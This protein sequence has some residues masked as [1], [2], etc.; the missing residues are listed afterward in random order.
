MMFSTD[1]TGQDA[2]NGHRRACSPLPE[3]KDMQ[4]V[5]DRPFQ[6][7]RRQRRGADRER[8]GRQPASLHRLEHRARRSPPSSTAS[9]QAG[10]DVPTATTDGNM[11]YA[12]MTQYA[13][14]LPKQLYIPAAQWVVHDRNA[15][16]RPRSRRQQQEFYEAFEAAGRQARHRGRAR[17]G[18]RDDRDRG[19][20]Q[21]RHRRR[22]R[23]RCATISPQL[24][25]YAG[26]NG[27]YDFVKRRSAASTSRTRW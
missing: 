3:N 5:A 10:L 22:R 14:F 19:A 18:R 6:H 25:G 20:A 4:V 16:R 12:Q 27:I 15:A 21:A 2:E 23:R 9:V 7:H 17:L 26:V 1:A 11:T 8:E 24:K 13:D